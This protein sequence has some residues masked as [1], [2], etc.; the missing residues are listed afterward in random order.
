VYF[1]FF[2][3]VIKAVKGIVHVEL[4]MAL[5]GFCSSVFIGRPSPSGCAQ[6][7]IRAIQHIYA[8]YLR[9]SP[10]PPLIVNTMGWMKG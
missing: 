2:I 6:T 9:L 4:W 3:N 1:L 10:R 5:V 7:Y 8:A